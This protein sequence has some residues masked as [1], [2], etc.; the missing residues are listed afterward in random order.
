MADITKTIY[1]GELLTGAGL[2]TATQN[3]ILNCRQHRKPVVFEVEIVN[4]AAVTVK[5]YVQTL[6]DDVMS[7]IQKDA[8]EHTYTAAAGG[9]KIIPI[10]PTA[11]GAYKIEVTGNAGTVHISYNVQF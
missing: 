1:T 7:W 8:T 9:S 11:S 4:T 3:Y 10:S 6:K 5:V 2:T